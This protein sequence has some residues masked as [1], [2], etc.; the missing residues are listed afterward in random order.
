LLVLLLPL[1]IFIGCTDSIVEPIESNKVEKPSSIYPIYIVISD[2]DTTLIFNFERYNSTHSVKLDALSYQEVTY[3]GV[4]RIEEYD[5]TVYPIWIFIY[6]NGYTIRK[7]ITFR[8]Q[9]GADIKFYITPEQYQYLL[10]FNLP[11]RLMEIDKSIF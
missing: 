9:F 8:T 5:G 11:E 7:F 4:K 1:F 3:F 2:V 6:D 10:R